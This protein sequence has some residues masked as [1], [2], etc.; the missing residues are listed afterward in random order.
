MNI[1]EQLT[2]V[3]YYRG[4]GNGG[5][6]QN[7]YIVV[8]Y[9]GAVS[10][11]KN[12]ADYF[13]S[14]NRQASANYFVDEN[15]IYRVVKDSD[16]AWHVGA[17][18]YY[19]DARNTN[20][21]GIEM[22]CYWNNGKLD[23]SEKVISNTIELVK[24]LM[25]KYNIPASHVAR[26]YDV[27]RKN[28][29]AP[30][31]ENPARWDDFKA[32]L[33]GSSKPINNNKSNEQVAYEVYCGL[34]GNGQDRK[35]KL[36]NAGYNPLTIQD[37]VNSKY[38][39][40]KKVVAT[41]SID[42]VAHEVINGAWGNGADRRNRVTAAGYNYDEVQ[43]RVNEI[44]LGTSTPVNNRK[45]NEQIAQEVINGAWGN[46][47]DRKNRLTAAGYDASAIQKIV[48]AKLLR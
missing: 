10:T 28:C 33:G 24:D 41:K 45:S 43:K 36:T 8:H 5:T 39:G 19:N 18:Q 34:W 7:K 6:K 23:V 16:S 44:L 30:L 2:Q 40:V 27:T 1:K 3:N 35:D 14:V 21:I 38:Y 29:P 12:N 47:Q 37:I 42:T 22:C 4:N 13:F 20:S 48:N 32:R 9:V 17:N 46:G 26:H 11:A 31:V 25:A 15:E